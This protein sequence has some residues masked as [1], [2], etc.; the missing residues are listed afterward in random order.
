MDFV[1]IVLFLSMYYLRPQEWAGVLNKIHPV[2][3][4]MILAVVALVTR[5]R[6]VRLKELFRTPHHWVMY[7]YFGWIIFTSQTPWETFGEI[8]NV[9]LFYI[10]IVLTL[11]DFPRIRRFLGWWAV[12][13]MVIVIAALAS[14]FGVDP[15]GSHDLTE[16][17]MKGRLA[18]N[19]AIFNNP[20]AL[21]HSVV[22]VIPMLFFLL[23]WKRA[24]MKAGIL[25]LALPLWC[26]YLTQSK[27]AF[28][29][30]FVTILMTLTFGRPK[31]VQALILALAVAFGSAALYA[32][33]RMD[34]LHKAKADEAIKGRLAAYTFGLECMRT[35][36]TGIGY[37]K[38]VAEFFRHGPLREKGE[39]AERLEK[40]GQRRILME[41]YQ[42]APH[43]SYNENGSELGYPGLFLFLAILYCCFRTVITAKTA[44]VEEER[45]RRIL[46]VIIVS[47]A[48]SSWM[49]DFAY[50]TTFFMFVAAT[51]AFH[52]LLY[53]T[54]PEREDEEADESPAYAPMFPGAVFPQ[55]L[56]AGLALGPMPMIP[57]M[58]M[59]G[60]AQVAEARPVGSGPAAERDDDEADESPPPVMNWR[61]FGI[62]DLALTCALT[63]GVVKYWAYIIHHI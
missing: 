58:Q 47:Y 5:E 21:G 55:P 33:P 13:I 45:I 1:S 30:C 10:V 23:F 62:I 16:G 43:G 26:I 41:H 38:F 53:R 19:L 59:S 36:S 40:N 15:L 20:N 24:F 34:E 49:I 35:H 12:M 9:M 7:A 11:T 56:V 51:A 57:A 14:K 46:F 31:A 29:C 8:R 61:R 48:V 52:R 6:G 25:L 22:P 60:A 42:K 3:V 54:T 4:S 44:S 27:G 63:Y 32:L 17:P 39:H 50:R 28:L 18:L 2:Q 37:L